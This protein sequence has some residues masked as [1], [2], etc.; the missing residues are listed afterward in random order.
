MQNKRS[1]GVKGKETSQNQRFQAMFDTVLD[2]VITIDDQ[3]IIETFN[4]SAV[5]L[6]GYSQDEV[7]GKNV[8]MLMG[9]PHRAKH[10]DYLKRYLETDEKRVIGIGRE[11]V[12]R[13]K[14]GRFFPFELAVTEMHVDNKRM[15]T[16]IVRDMSSQEGYRRLLQ[17]ITVAQQELSRNVLPMEIFEKLLN[18]LLELTQSEYGFIGEIHHDEKGAPY[19]T[20]H[21]IT[22]IAWNA[23]TRNFYEANVAQGLKFKNLDTLFGR[24]ITT[25]EPVL[26]NDPSH[27]PRKGGL[28]K[29]HPSLDAFLGL[30]FFSREEFVGMVGIANRPG[31]YSEDMIEFLTPFLTTCSNLIMT[32]R[33]DKKRVEAEKTLRE[34]EARGRAILSGATEAIVTVNEKGIVE[35]ANPATESIFGYRLDEIIGNN[36]KMLM[37]N[38]FHSEHDQYIKNYVETG[39]RKVIGVGREVIGLRK[40]GQQFPMFLSISHITVG[41]RNMFTGVIRDISEQKRNAEELRQLNEDLSNRVGALD[42]LN[43]INAQLNKMNS[44][45][46][47]AE[48]YEELYETLKKFG[49]VIFPSEA[50]AFFKIENNKFL[51]KCASWG[52]KYEGDEYFKISECWALRQGEMKVQE[53]HDGHLRCLHLG[54]LEMNHAICQPVSTRDGV[55]G[56]LSI[57]APANL[58]ESTED[59]R[60]RVDRNK[61]VLVA[62]A[63]RLGI[64]VSNLQLREKLKQESIRDPLTRLYNRRFLDETLEIE[65][66]RSQRN[67][68]TIA[69]ILLDADH[70]KSFNDTYGHDA[71]D[72]VLQ[73]IAQVLKSSARKEDLPCRYGG[74]EFALALVGMSAEKAVQK[75]E[76]IRQKI[77]ELDIHYN[78][79]PLP[80][81]TISCGVAAIPEHGGT[82]SACI[83]E[84]DKALYRAKENGRNRV[85]LA[86][87]R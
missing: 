10:D 78:G 58:D 77:E 40:N 27:D 53:P 82:Q 45:F 38:P 19:L 80:K 15:F 23:E 41:G 52:S 57:Y 17:A 20:T 81:I 11:V 63:D 30:P 21:A 26:S 8:S 43:E 9:E 66:K 47:T 67:N 76:E 34:S 85:E 56:L 5:R 18:E 42:V 49:S 2:G 51:E 25:G 28:P 87:Q 55:I 71:G 24:V 33:Y 59:M 54:D 64:A 86:K 16:G 73:E 39:I 70:F 83:K 62:I 72:I 75:A 4:P 12:G 44:F 48:T 35:D 74:E 37:P 31:G 61:D 3:G 13:R 7:I 36:V 6:F 1:S 68:S 32:L 60:V 50:G 46:Q 29:G 22:N 14:D 84:A 79:K 69:I 65:I